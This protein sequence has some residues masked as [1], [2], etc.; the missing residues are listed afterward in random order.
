[1]GRTCWI[2][3][4]ALCLGVT[5]GQTAAA[6]PTDRP[7]G[8][9][10]MMD[11]AGVPADTLERA[12]NDAT[13]VFELSGITLVW[14][15]AATCQARCL[16]VRIV[17]EPVGT[18]SRDP[19]VLGV[20]TGTKEARGKHLWII[21]PRIRAYS[22]QL[23]LDASQLLGH[24]I[25]H[26]LGHLL[27]PH[28]AHSLSGIMRPAWDRPQVKGATQGTLTFTPDQVDRIRTGLQASAS[29]IARAR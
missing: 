23:G 10:L 13:R 7:I 21:Y 22:A 9:V 29:P 27:L 3:G 26:E 5:A 16:T 6:E 28:G 19:R 2:A 17:L 18:K 24:V 1:M 14:I 25:A 11:G 20:A 8:E 4:L 12:Q 15:E